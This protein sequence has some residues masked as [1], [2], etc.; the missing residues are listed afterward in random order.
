MKVEVNVKSISGDTV[1]LQVA[2]A[3]EETVSSLKA[4][5]LMAEPSPFPEHRLL[6]R[7]ELLEDALTLSD[8]G[9]QDGTVLNFE[10]TGNAQV[11][12]NQLASLLPVRG[13]I[14][15]EELGLLY[16]LKH[17]VT[18]GAVLQ[19]MGKE[20]QQLLPA[21]LGQFP[22]LFSLDGG[23]VHAARQDGSATIAAQPLQ[24]IPEDRAVQRFTINVAVT[25]ELPYST[26]AG[27]SVKITANASDT[28]AELKEMAAAA[29]QL[30]F[31]D[32]RLWHDHPLE[33]AKSLAACG[34]NDSSTI[35]LVVRCTEIAL[36]MQLMG[37]LRE[38][39]PTSRTELD[40]LYCLRFGSSATQALT[41]L[42]WGEKL[43]DFLQRQSVFAVQG[44]C[45]ALARESPPAPRSPRFDEE[46]QRFL[47]LHSQLTEDGAL[48]GLSEELDALKELVISEVFLNVLRVERGGGVENGTAVRGAVGAE[49]VLFVDGLQ[50]ADRDRWLPSLA[51]A[52]AAVLSQ[53]LV[54]RGGVVGVRV[55]ADHA[56]HLATAGRL[57]QVRVLISPAFGSYSQAL[58][59]LRGQKPD[60]ARSGGEAA[61]VSQ[62][63]R[64]V[65]RQPPAVKA[66]VRLLKHWCSK[67]KWSSDVARPGDDLLT[68]VAAAS[69]GARQPAD[70]RAG[71]EAS[72]A[73]LADFGRVEI[74]TWPLACRTYRETDIPKSVLTRRPL[75]LDPTNPLANLADPAC[76]D[77][78]EMMRH[79]RRGF[80]F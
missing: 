21:F 78:S 69:V 50:L 41:L 71:V 26:V 33:D 12:A 6:L 3:S 79:A 1:K 10:S 46:N 22:H 47:Q 55:A 56:V 64:F 76:L 73:A 16:T 30:P 34:L 70:L 18:A 36:V 2:S 61:F 32:R 24:K 74:S 29:A 51:A 72:L 38:R 37:L 31:P 77:P 14:S 44:G 11:L 45:I 20:S 59:A 54:G 42:G 62:R 63:V 23:L 39:G 80:H 8:Y 60:A 58:A 67:Q 68:C 66:V 13:G 48:A 19:T 49:L 28:V 27:E 5:I 65:A 15:A 75:V 35:R 52:V 17:G 9:I 40:N 43:Q 7:E 25:L 53:R 4:R 57:G